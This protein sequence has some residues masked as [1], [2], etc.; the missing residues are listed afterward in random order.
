MVENCIFL[1]TDEVEHLSVCLLD[2]WV[3]SSVMCVLK[4]FAHLCIGFSVFC[5]DLQKLDISDTSA[6]L[7]SFTANVFSHIWYIFPLNNFF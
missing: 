4:V 6:S 3:P 2:T 5:I 1:I 7:I